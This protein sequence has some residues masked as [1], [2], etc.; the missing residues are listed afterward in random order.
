MRWIIE[1]VVEVFIFIIL[2]LVIWAVISNGG[3]SNTV[4][5]VKEDGLKKIVED[6]WY[7]ENNR[8]IDEMDSI[9]REGDGL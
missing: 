1:T 9:E 7:G 3:I 8:Y 5:I 6:V 4:D 2:V